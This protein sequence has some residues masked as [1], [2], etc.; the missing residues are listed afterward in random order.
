MTSPCRCRVPSSPTSVDDRTDKGKVGVRLGPVALSFAGTVKF[1]EIDDT[2]HKAR[3]AAQG[4]DA[5]GR[6]A[7]RTRPRR[8]IWS[9]R[10]AAPWR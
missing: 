8:S 9:L 1:E 4:N 3:V 2:N 10:A 7:A 6:G 5:K